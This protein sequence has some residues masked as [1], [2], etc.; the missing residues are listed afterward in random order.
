MEMMV[1]M[2]EIIAKNTA[3]YI[4]RSAFRSILAILIKLKICLL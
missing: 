1:E 4:E 2:L 3:K